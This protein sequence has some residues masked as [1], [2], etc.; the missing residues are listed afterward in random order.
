M[1]IIIINST[2]SQ[3]GLRSTSQSRCPDPG[4]SERPTVS[5][6]FSHEV[7]AVTLHTTCRPAVGFQA[8][9]RDGTPIVSSFAGVQSREEDPPKPITPDTAVFLAS[10]TKLLTSISAL[11]LVER[12]LIALDDPVG[13]FVKQVD[14]FEM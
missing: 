10:C 6:T 5:A 8:Y 1:H 3:H 14:E 9:A 13:K 4:S 11:Q 12:G 7:A 2:H